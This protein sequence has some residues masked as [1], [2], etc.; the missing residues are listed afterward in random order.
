M[1]TSDPLAKRG[2]VR[3]T[4]YNP[5]HFEVAKV[6]LETGETV[7]ALIPLDDVALRACRERSMTIGSQWKA[8]VRQVRNLQLWR[9]AH[10]LGGWL[11]DNHEVFAGDTAHD[12]IKRLQ[13]LSG[14][15]CTTTRSD[16]RDRDGDLLYRVVSHQP[17]SLAFDLID[18]GT[19]RAFWDGGVEARG[20]GGWLG[21]MRHHLYAGMDAPDVEELEFLIT[22]ERDL[23]RE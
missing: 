10:L 11:A 1:A 22:G 3:K 19:F 23:W 4:D 13:R 12:A 14:V 16:I 20:N 8:E 17:L 2:V 21:W 18:E 9:F 7:G 5:I 6:T 15:G